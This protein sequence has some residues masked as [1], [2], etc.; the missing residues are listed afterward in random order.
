MAAQLKTIGVPIKLLHEAE[1]H[2]VTVELKNGEI[3]RGLLQ[4]AEDTM[5]CKIGEVTMTAKDGRVTKLEQVFLRGGQVK[6][7]VLPELLKSAPVFKKVQS[8]RAKGG[9]RDGTGGR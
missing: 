6:F 3:Y 1:G 4:E 8:M 2:V 7:V 5:N 9:D